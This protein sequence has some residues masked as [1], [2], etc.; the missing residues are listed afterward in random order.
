MNFII[1]INRIYDLDGKAITLGGIQTYLVQLCNII[2]KNYNVKPYIY[3]TANSDFTLINENYVVRGVGNKTKDKSLKHVIERVRIDYD[4]K[5][6]VVIWGSDQYSIKLDGYK[7]INIQHGI[8]FDTEAVETKLKKM[9]LDLNFGCLYKYLQRLKARKHVNNGDIVVC[10][11]YNFNNWIRTYLWNSSDKAKFRVIPNFTESLD[12]LDNK[13][14]LRKILVAR[15]FVKRRGIGLAVKS[16]ENI[17]SDYDSVEFTFAGDGPERKL[18][19][20]LKEKFPGRVV[21]TKYSQERSLEFHRNYDIALVPSIGSEGT[22][23]SLLEAMGAGCIPIAT[24][25]GGMTNIIIDNYNG[26]LVEP[27]VFSL[28]KQIRNC[29]DQ[30]SSLDEIRISAWETA[31]KGFDVKLWEKKWISIINEVIESE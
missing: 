22:S 23:L 30:K 7:T 4:S 21:I 9:L 5:D 13:T 26:F 8:G 2:K 3:Q 6:T 27:D 10:V 15:R 11:D 25:V 18:V 31:K 17:L 19:E 1:V 12:S 14:S 24:N 29:L 16:A 20:S 28:T